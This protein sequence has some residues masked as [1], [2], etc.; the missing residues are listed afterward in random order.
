MT[1]TC[2][3]SA[4]FFYCESIPGQRHTFGTVRGN[5]FET[6]ATNHKIIYTCMSCCGGFSAGFCCMQTNNPTANDNSTTTTAPTMVTFHNID[7]PFFL[8]SSVCGFSCAPCVSAD[9]FVSPVS[10]VSFVIFVAGVRFLIDFLALDFV[11]FFL[12]R[13][14]GTCSFGPTSN[15]SRIFNDHPFFRRYHTPPPSLSLVLA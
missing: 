10:R 11:T 6:I 9:L 1:E 7:I 4:S 12:P 14:A 13:F 2:C 15:W 5:V 8:V 3:H